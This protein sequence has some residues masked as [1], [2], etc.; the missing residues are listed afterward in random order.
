[1]VSLWTQSPDAP[2]RWGRVALTPR[3]G[4]ALVDF[5]ER[6]EW[7][8]QSGVGVG[9]LFSEEVNGQITTEHLQPVPRGRCLYGRSLVP[10]GFPGHVLQKEYALA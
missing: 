10:E 1:M 4:Y 2:L 6:Q 5:R 9:V 3:G 7:R 8:A